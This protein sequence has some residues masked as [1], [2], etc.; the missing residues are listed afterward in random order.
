VTAAPSDPPHPTDGA[1]VLDDL[2]WRGLIAQTTD[3]D[4]LRRDL[5][6]GS[7]T[8]YCGF[9]PTAESLHLGNL[10]PLFALRR[11]QL[12]GHRPIALAGGA[13]GFIGDP[14]GRTAERVMMTSDVVAERVV[15]IRRQM[16]RFLDFDGPSGAVLVDNLEWT[17]PMS[18]LEFLRDVGQHFSIN[19]MLGKESVSARLEAG[20]LTFTEFS[21]M[22]LQSFDYL[23][24]H[25]RFG[26][27]L[28]IGGN[29]Q[30]GNITAGLDLIRRVEGGDRSAHALTLPLVTDAGGAKIGKSTGGGNVWADPALTSPYALYQFLLNVDDR[31]VGTYLRLLTFLPREQ[32]EQL[33]AATLERPQARAA[34]RAL[35]ESLTALIHGDQE[36]VQVQAA[37][38]ALFGGGALEDLDEA[39]LAA[40]LAEAPSTTVAGEPPPLVDLLAAALGISKSDARRAVREGGAYLNNRKLT[41]EAATPRP[42]DWLHGRFLVLRRGK[43]TVAVVERTS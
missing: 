40:A 18:A 16:E 6:A 37:S 35:A 34:Q 3:V 13:T 1:A 32:V 9:D 27:R 31:D 20:G 25:R 23:E 41:D 10:V 19:A 38:A 43:R 28:Q 12:A 26:C 29:D 17:A 24:L 2:S 42:E 36:L 30:W 22:L 8:L 5:A 4:A 39:T 33:D 15:R 14:T 11:F 7:L 21:Y